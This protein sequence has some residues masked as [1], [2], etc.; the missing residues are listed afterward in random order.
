MSFVVV[1]CSCLVLSCLVLPCLV[2]SCLVLPWLVLA[3]FLVLVLAYGVSPFFLRL[4]FGFLVLLSLVE[5]LS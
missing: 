5:V 3:L 1:L 2:L 4:V